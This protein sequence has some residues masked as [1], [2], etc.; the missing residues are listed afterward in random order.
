VPEVNGERA[1]YACPRGTAYGY[2][3][4]RSAAWRIRYRS[5][6]GSSLA[7]VPITVAYF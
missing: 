7:Q 5:S 6:S 1:N 3:D 2:P 4:R